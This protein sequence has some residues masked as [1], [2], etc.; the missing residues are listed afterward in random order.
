MFI[1]HGQG[2]LGEVVNHVGQ[3]SRLFRMVWWDDEIL[4]G[5]IKAPSPADGIWMGASWLSITCA[6]Y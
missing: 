5:R 6:G 3:L 2:K 1:V 4:D